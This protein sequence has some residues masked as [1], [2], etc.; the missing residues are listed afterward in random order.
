L[1][2]VLGYL[3][4]LMCQNQEGP[5]VPEVLFKT[6]NLSKPWPEVPSK[7]NNETKAGL[8]FQPAVSDALLD[9]PKLLG[10]THFFTHTFFRDRVTHPIVYNFLKPRRGGE[11]GP[12][13][14]PWLEGRNAA[15]AN[16]VHALLPPG[17]WKNA[18]KSIVSD[19]CK[20]FFT[21]EFRY[22][23]SCNPTHETE[24]RTANRWGTTNSKPPGRIVWWAI[25]NT[26]QQSYHLYYTFF[27]RWNALLRLLPATPTLCNY[28]ETKPFSWTKPAILDFFSSS[29]FNVQDHILS[30][31]GNALGAGGPLNVYHMEQNRQHQQATNRK[32][33]VVWRSCM[34]ARSSY[35]S[36]SS[37]SGERS[38][39]FIQNINSWSFEDTYH[40]LEENLHLLVP[41]LL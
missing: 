14:Q 1:A 7:W 31:T 9:Y 22:L 32:N 8:K 27:S 4:L 41:W 24:T 16:D 28:S 29:N 2:K 11:G 37:G 26:D 34:N 3:N 40:M 13:F 10:S 15:P 33:I 36:W 6:K 38:S 17:S 18:I 20:I 21:S 19:P 39:L 30:T 5:D 25:R 23:L 35:D 12:P